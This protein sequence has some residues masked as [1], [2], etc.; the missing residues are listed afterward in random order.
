MK[1]DLGASVIVISLAHCCTIL[2]TPHHK[3]TKHKVLIFKINSYN[4]S[5]HLCILLLTNL[6][7]IVEIRIKYKSGYIHKQVNYT[8]G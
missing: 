8:T 6:F 4:N 3:V 7:Q 1:S 2:N 5:V